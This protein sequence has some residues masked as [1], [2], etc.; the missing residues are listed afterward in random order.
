MKPGSLHYEIVVVE[1]NPADF[2][3]VQLALKEHGVECFL[4]PVHDGEQ[5]LN[6]I[7]SLDSSA[8]AP[9]LDLMILDMHLPKHDGAEILKRLRSTEN[10]GLTPVV[11]MTALTSPMTEAAANRHAA[12]VYFHK[13]STFNEFMELGSIV[14]TLL[15]S[16]HQP[17]ETPERKKEAAK[18]KR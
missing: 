15:Q 7:D 14:R 13:P 6:L 4:H 16:N 5:A 8:G 9:R 18:G 17:G 1:D 11:V 12:L 2:A 3:L 10:Y